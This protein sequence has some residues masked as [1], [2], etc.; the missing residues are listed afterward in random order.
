MDSDFWY[1]KGVV[2]NQ[3]EK[4]EAALSCYMQALTL[5]SDHT[6][7]IFN[8]ACSYE[9]LQQ[10]DEAKKWFMKAIAVKDDW[11]DAYYGLSLVCIRLGQTKE[12][13]DAINQAVSHSA[14]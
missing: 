12:A 13:V 2:L 1:H 4:N 8:L 10:Y 11:P 6:P 9:K 3:K 7:S 14:G 5:Q